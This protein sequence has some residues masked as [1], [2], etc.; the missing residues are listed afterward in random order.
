[1]LALSAPTSTSVFSGSSC[2]VAYTAGVEKTKFHYNCP[3][4]LPARVRSRCYLILRIIRSPTYSLR[5]FELSCHDEC[6]KLDSAPLWPRRAYKVTVETYYFPN[7]LRPLVPEG[8]G[9]IDRSTPMW[10]GTWGRGRLQG[11]VY[12]VL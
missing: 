2:S 9:L 10:L 8:R 6:E 1:M 7:F 11:I 3:G 5:T 4:A 12:C